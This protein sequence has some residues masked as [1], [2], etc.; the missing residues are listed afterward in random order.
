MLVFVAVET[1]RL[2]L[3]IKIESFELYCVTSG[4]RSLIKLPRI[5]YRAHM[6]VKIG[7]RREKDW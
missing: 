1:K 4:L 2:H 5:V 7:I 6:D 3:G